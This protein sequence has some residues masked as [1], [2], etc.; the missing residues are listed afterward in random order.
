MQISI[1]HLLIVIGGTCLNML[2]CHLASCYWN[3]YDQGSQA[4]DYHWI[5]EPLKA[6]W[7]YDWDEDEE[8]DSNKA[9]ES[10]FGGDI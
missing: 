1:I 7:D 8:V 3:D 6:L 10:N 5:I 9:E 2:Y 4:E